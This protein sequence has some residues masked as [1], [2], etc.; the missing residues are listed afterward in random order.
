MS[1]PP[2][3]LLRAARARLRGLLAA[4][5]LAAPLAGQE[6]IPAAE[7]ARPPSAARLDALVA[8]A[9]DGGW[10]RWTG[11]LR[12]AAFEAYARDPATAAPWLHLHRWATL[13]AT[14]RAQAVEAWIGA[15]ERAGGAH[16][17]MPSRYDLPPGSLAGDVPPA[18]QR[19]ALGHADFSAEFFATVSPQDSPLELLRILGALHA[20]DPAAF[21]EYRS[22]ALAVAV[23]F[24]V[25]PPPDWPHGQVPPN[26]LAR[27][28]PPPTEAFAHWVRLDRANVAP[29]RLRRLPAA[30]LKYL[31]DAAAP[32]AELTW[33]RRNV[34]PPIG[35][36]GRAYDMIRY[37]TDRVAANQYHWPGRDY[38]LE[39]ILRE[40]GICVDQA[41]FA[42]QAGKAR[43]VPTLLFRGAGLDGRHAWF[44]YLAPDGWRMDVG[45]YAEQRFVAGFARDPQTWRELSDHEIR[46]LSERFRETPLFQLSALHAAFAAEFLRAG[47]AE[48]ARRAAREAASR[49]PR[50]LQAWQLL[51]SAQRAAGADLRAVEATLREAMLAL[52]RYPD[53]EVVFA[54]ELIAGL[55]A[56]GET[57]LADAEEQRLVRK[58]QAGR[59]DLSVQQ[60]AEILQRSLGSE[61]LA[62]RIRTYRRLLE[63]YGAGAGID[64]FD[65]IVAPFVEHLRAEGQVPAAREA[66][67]RARRTL[68][69]EKGQ[70]LDA[71]MRRL[72]EKLQVRR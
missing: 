49:E 27:R 50:N 31:V 30:E 71:E 39:T 66:L 72:A 33:A 43:G 68:R 10:G 2:V 48:A 11:P 45:R 6:A 16:R 1:R 9:A 38:R 65:R 25:P 15:I 59:S 51:V 47:D 28:L 22:L 44:G 4:G 19:W 70:Q 17:N 60:A 7:L 42:A 8:S 54:R 52:Q 18:L 5:A 29:H 46:F 36:L 20:A 37:R 23:V 57:S 61:D 12:T 14:P 35:E 3:R 32:F 40:G 13:F 63:T 24:D 58:H 64:F 21:A 67:E 56:R 62:A 53:L 26:L 55:R 41:Y 34:T 69:V